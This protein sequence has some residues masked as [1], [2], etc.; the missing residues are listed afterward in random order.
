[1]DL[2]GIEN[3]KQRNK[4]N[5]TSE[6]SQITSEGTYLVGMVAVTKTETDG[7]FKEPHEVGKFVERKLGEVR[8]IRITRGG[9]V[10]IECNS[11][12][13]RDRA[14]KIDAYCDYSCV[15]CFP[16]GKEGKK[17]GVNSGVWPV[18]QSRVISQY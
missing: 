11:R 8:S 2:K 14:L 16:L 15:A 6:S 1:M 10:I 13:Q 18:S 9:I 7:I 3:K 5:P 4:K 12:C 17:K